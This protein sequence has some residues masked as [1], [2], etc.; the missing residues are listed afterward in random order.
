[1]EAAIRWSPHRDGQRKRFLYVDVSDSSLVLNEI[2][3]I[4]ERGLEY[5]SV[6]KY[7]KLPHF[8]A[9][10]W[11]SVQESLVAIGH[12][13]GNTSLVR[14]REDDKPS[15]VLTTFK[16]KQQ[17]KC[18]SVAFNTQNWLAVAVDKTRSDVCLNI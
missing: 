6:A 1:M 3:K 7:N 18:N 17:R 13:S 14:L 15:E 16:I 11:S 10:A 12:V 9:F 4:S 8:A 2:D 5:H